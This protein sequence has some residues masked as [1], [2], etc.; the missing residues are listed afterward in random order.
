MTESMLAEMFFRVW[1]GSPNPINVMWATF[2]L[3]FLSI[4]LAWKIQDRV[5]SK[6]NVDTVLCLMIPKPFVSDL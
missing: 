6:R 3:T 1:I 2:Q 5:L 4:L